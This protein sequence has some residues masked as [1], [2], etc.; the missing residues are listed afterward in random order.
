MIANSQ[1][2]LELA[3]VTKVYPGFP[4]VQALHQV[5][6]AVAAG[7]LTSVAGPSGSGKTTL[8]H[9]MGTLDKPASGTCASLA[10]TSRG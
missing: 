8:L 6:L 2:V 3:H 4:P 9:L 5:S 7:E 1:P 10:W